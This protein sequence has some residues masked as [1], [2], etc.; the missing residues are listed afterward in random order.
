MTLGAIKKSWKMSK[1]LKPS[2]ILF[3]NPFRLIFVSEFKLFLL[4][5]LLKLSHKAFQK[6]NFGV[7]IIFWLRP[8]RSRPRQIKNPAVSSRVIFK[9]WGGWGTVRDDQHANR[10]RGQS[11]AACGHNRHPEH[12]RN[13]TAGQRSWRSDRCREP[14]GQRLIRRS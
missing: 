6:A 14:T 8:V 2:R 10:I 4:S 5:L 11:L 13:R 1:A 7:C 3:F 9:L 12:R